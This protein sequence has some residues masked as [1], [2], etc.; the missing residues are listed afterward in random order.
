[1]DKKKKA[2]LQWLWNPSQTNGDKLNNVRC[3]INRTFSNKKSRYLKEKFNELE[4]NSKNKNIRDYMR[5]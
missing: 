3:E 1:L 4:T 5:A 2:K